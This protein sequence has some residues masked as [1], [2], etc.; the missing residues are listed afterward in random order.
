VLTRKLLA[1]I[2]LLASLWLA[3]STHVFAAYT[4]HT[5]NLDELTRIAG[6]YLAE[7]TKNLS[8]RTEIVVS[9]LDNRLRLPAC[10]RP[11][12]YQSQG[13]KIW[14]KTTVAIRCENPEPWRI[15][16]RAH[17]KI[18][19]S[20]LTAARVLPLG[21]VINESDLT[22]VTS[23]ITALRPG[24]LTEMNHAVGRTV[25]RAIQPGRAIRPEYLRASK[26]IQSGQAVRIVGKGSGFVV[27]GEGHATS[28]A[29]EGQVIKV[30]MAN[31]SVVRGIAKSGGI[32]EVN[33]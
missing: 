23:D 19:S 21:H 2:L 25:A 13:A 20:Y 17:V 33:F 10:E 8:G 22:A 1:K 15:M 7:N 5:Q 9:P 16:V 26:A 24:V 12:P 4:Q 29:D 18:Y 14:G 11:V 31:G 28:S 27:S 3:A 6:Q 32:I 30:K